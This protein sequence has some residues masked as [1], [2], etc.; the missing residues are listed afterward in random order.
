MTLNS[1]SVNNDKFLNF[2]LTSFIEIPAY[3]GTYFV[4]DRWGR[5]NT[6]CASFLI[7]AGSCIVDAFVPTGKN[8][9]ISL[10]ML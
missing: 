1:V 6:L 7:C 5:R 8:V 9:K 2:I 10:S 4:L 3:V